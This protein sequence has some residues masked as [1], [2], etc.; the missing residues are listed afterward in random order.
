MTWSEIVAA[1]TDAIVE[2]GDQEGTQGVWD[3]PGNSA[4]ARVAAEWIVAWMQDRGLVSFDVE[5]L[6]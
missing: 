1:L 5:I 3:E 6:R 2:N 4:D